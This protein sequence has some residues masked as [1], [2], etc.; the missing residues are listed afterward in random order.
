MYTKLLLK[1][2][3][4]LFFFLSCSVHFLSAQ[5]E[6]IYIDFGSAI[7]GYESTA[8]WNNITSNGS[9]NV[10]NNL[11]NTNASDTGISIAITDGFEGIN[12]SGTSTPNSSLN[13]EGTATRDS[14]FGSD[15]SASTDSSTLLLSNL[16]VDK[17]YS[18][19][20]FAS[21][22]GVSDNRETAYTID[23][24]VL[25]TIS[26]DPSNNTDNEATITFKSKADGTATIEVA[27]GIN[28]NNSAGYFYL[29]IIKLVYPTN[30]PIYSDNALFVDF[31][32]NSNPTTGNW[33]NLT[34]ALSTGS[35]DNLV[36]NGGITTNI[37]L[38]VT[39][40]FNFI[41]ENGTTTLGQSLGFPNTATADSFFG[42]TVEYLEKTEPTGA[43][44]YSNF[45]ANTDLSLTIYSSRMEY[46]EVDNRETMY[47]IEGLT[48]EIVYL[49]ATNNINNSIS[50]T[51]KPKADGT[52][53]ITVN[54][55]PNNNNAYGF[56]YLGAMAIEYS[57]DPAIT[58]NTPNGGEFWQQGKTTSISWS[59][60]AL[61]SSIV[62]EYSTDNGLNWNTIANVPYTS[63]HYDWTVPNVVSENCLVRAT[64]NLVSDTSDAVFEISN[65]TTTCNIVVIGSSTAEGTGASTP[66]KSWVNL[67]AEAIYQ[68]NTKLNV[69][70]L[71]KGGYTTYHVLPTG[72]SIPS[73][74]STTIDTERNI[75]KALSFNPIAI[76]VNMPS[77]DTAEGYPVAD[78]LANYSTIYNEAANS[79][80]PMWI[81]T[82]QPRNFSAAK[83]QDQIDVRNALLTAYTTNAINF[84]EDIADTDGTILD[85]LDFGD[86]THVNDTGHELLFHKVFATSIAD[87][88]CE[89]DDTLDTGS[90][91]ET[92][93]AVHAFPNPVKDELHISFNTSMDGNYTLELFDVL[94]KEILQ[95]SA[96]FHI[97]KNLDT[98]NLS[99][100]HSQVLLGRITFVKSD[101]S[102]SKEQFKLV[103][104]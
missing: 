7:A 62:L 38:A 42:N 21:R 9:G 82:T 89:M 46:V 33:N 23:G 91:M 25:Q 6:T 72:T 59:S 101:G 95:I 11:L 34:N 31:G 60:A 56:F 85:G 18:I 40:D 98:Y 69:I 78:Q 79:T 97:G 96:N 66:E 99:A 52:L 29:G 15:A 32:I 3:I 90:F 100:L 68:K 58:L 70:N 19:S 65:D 20:I 103:V 81:T 83:I 55:G 77:N 27:K 87:L 80:V 102:V 104:K 8:S 84:W 57:P 41:N 76:I 4:L 5:T 54:K 93:F 12:L 22:T 73:G 39:D 49:N 94:G 51:L 61:S 92:D 37:S 44:T 16:V 45:D 67:Y 43:I 47:T 24:E 30:A 10:Y 14:F 63:N 36:N 74:I 1:S 75:T 35:L 17:T 64:S 2:K 48:T 50:T 53:T 13:Y 71:G 26:L 86:G 28:N 88:E